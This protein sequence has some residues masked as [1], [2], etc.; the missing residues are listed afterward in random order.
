MSAFTL[1]MVIFFSPTLV[2]ADWLG[3]FYNSAGAHVNVTH[4]QGISTQ[5]S[6]GRSGGGLVWRVPN[7]SFYPISITPPSLKAGCGGIDLYLG[8]FSFPNKAEFVQALRNFGQ[9][10]LGYFFKLALR[11]LAP[12][13]AVTLDA[14]GDIANTINQF[15][16][17]TCKM[18]EAVAGNA[19]KMLNM[20]RRT[21]AA[22]YVRS[23]G[24]F[25]D[26]FDARF[27]LQGKGNE[28]HAAIYANRYG[29]GKDF[30]TVTDADVKKNGEIPPDANVLHWALLK[31]NSSDFNDTEREMIMA[32]VGPNIIINRQQ[33]DDAGPVQP[34]KYD[35]LSWNQIL[36]AN[37][38]K[39]WECDQEPLCTNPHEKTID[40]FVSFQVRVEKAVEQIRNNVATRQSGNNLSA[41]TKL[42]IRLS[43]VPIYRA[44]AMAESGGVGATLASAILP[45]LITYAA[46]DATANFVNAYLTEALRALDLAVVPAPLKD[47]VQGMK[48]KIFEKRKQMYV[49][50][51]NEFAKGG[52]PYQYI[53]MLDKIERAMYSNLNTGIAGN[54]KF[55]K[56]L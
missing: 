21:E 42:V 36:Y 39:V 46:I 11:S 50:I 4:A 45:D 2:Q 20:D 49:E 55:G 24:E 14:I 8:G 56:R 51:Q 16:E 29:P 5:S 38:I 26:D 18:A 52:N 44:A 34:K 47:E 6:V 43:S 37:K 27:G 15:G 32:L 3:D 1:G 48:Q 28:S 10:A 40:P 33:G 25:V 41:D 13:I 22:G 9:A 12:E 19:V 31:A 17:N 23:V 30:N 53:D 54:S 35:L 7:R